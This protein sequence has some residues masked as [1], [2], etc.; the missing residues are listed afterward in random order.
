MYFS[1]LNRSGWGQISRLEDQTKVLLALLGA[2]HRLGNVI[3]ASPFWLFPWLLGHGLD[4]GLHG[5][6]LIRRDRIAHPVRLQLVDP[7]RRVGGRIGPKITDSLPLG[8]VL[9]TLPIEG[10]MPRARALVALPKLFQKTELGLKEK[11]QHR[12]IALHFLIGESRLPLL[13]LNLRRIHLQGVFPDP[14]AP[15]NARMDL[16]AHPPQTQKPPLPLL[17]ISHAPEPIPYTV[18]IG[19]LL[20]ADQL[21]QGPFPLQLPQIFQAPAPGLQHQNQGPPQDHIRDPRH[22]CT[23]QGAPNPRAPSAPLPSSRSQLRLSFHPLSPPALKGFTSQVRIHSPETSMPRGLSYFFRPSI[24]VL[25][26]D[27]PGFE[28]VLEPAAAS[29]PFYRPFIESIVCY[30][31]GRSLG[32]RWPGRLIKS[33]LPFHF[34]RFIIVA[35]IWDF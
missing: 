16:I 13:C 11:A 23:A 15:Q 34:G 32:L 22:G 19:D 14:I 20:P 4:Q 25:G 35:A 5:L 26:I 31:P 7:L 21:H 6:V 3:P 29:R 18:R 9:L 24:S 2:V 1:P 33:K 8:H 27:I 10:H 12:Q 28:V 30:P 17:R